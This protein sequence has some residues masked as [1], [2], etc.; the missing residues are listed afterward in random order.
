MADSK[1][2]WRDSNPELEEKIEK[3]YSKN[4]DHS[5]YSEQKTHFEFEPER[6]LRGTLKKNDKMSENGSLDTE[7]DTF[8]GVESREIANTTT[9]LPTTTLLNSLQVKRAI[10]LF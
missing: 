5:P 3:T 7:N 2:R 1:S 4:R 9:T 6:K 8:E 10:L